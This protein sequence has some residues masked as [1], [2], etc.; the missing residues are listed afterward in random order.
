MSTNQEILEA[1]GFYSS[2]RVA[3][4]A[5]EDAEPSGTEAFD[6]HRIKSAPD[7]K[8]K[9]HLS[10]T[11]LV[12]VSV[13]VTIAVVFLFCLLAQL[14]DIQFWAVAGDTV[15][16]LSGVIVVAG[17]WIAWVTN[18]SRSKEAEKADFRD[19]MKWAVENTAHE[20]ELIGQYA[21]AIIR[22]FRSNQD[23]E[24]M[25]AEDKLFID[26]TNAKYQLRVEGREHAKTML[27]SYVKE[28]EQGLQTI[29]KDCGSLSILL[30]YRRQEAEMKFKSQAEIHPDTARREYVETLHQIIQDHLAKP[31]R[32]D[33]RR[34][35]LRGIRE[36]DRSFDSVR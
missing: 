35:P 30:E 26:E 34:L 1:G 27:E 23:Q 2:S 8:D 36:R 10:H 22:S 19:R 24:W 31:E 29:I 16:N 6:V 14:V 7:V 20:N 17:A 25:S 15:R 21:G 13:A 32:R 11:G 33:S 12:F 5:A 9:P 3:K 18:K 28:A 4:P